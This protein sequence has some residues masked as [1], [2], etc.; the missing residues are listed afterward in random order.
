[1]VA[2]LTSEAP[3]FALCPLTVIGWLFRVA[4]RAMTCCGIIG[5]AVVAFGFAKPICRLICE[6]EKSSNVAIAAKALR[7]FRFIQASLHKN[8][9]VNNTL[10]GRSLLMLESQVNDFSRIDPG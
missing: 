9:S 3:V 2:S 8:N 5:A 10:P 6:M 4:S 7:R 1:M